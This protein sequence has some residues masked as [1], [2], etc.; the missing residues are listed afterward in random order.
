MELFQ[1]VKGF[2]GTNARY[3]HEEELAKLKTGGATFI[4]LDHDE[5][6]GYELQH[7]CSL[8]CRADDSLTKREMLGI[9]KANKGTL[10]E[11]DAQRFTV[12]EQLPV[13][14]AGVAGWHND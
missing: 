8:Y 5:K 7:A 9:I 4:I 13:M 12:R 11:D 14:L 2:Q 3:F 10:I 6:R 1:V